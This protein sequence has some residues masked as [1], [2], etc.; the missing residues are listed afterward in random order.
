MGSCNILESHKSS[1]ANIVPKCNMVAPA[2]SYRCAEYD[3]R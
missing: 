2:T 3:F 1:V